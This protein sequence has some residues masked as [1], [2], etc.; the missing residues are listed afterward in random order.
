[1]NTSKK[2]FIATIATLT[3]LALALALGACGGVEDDV[4]FTEETVINTGSG[5][6]NYTCTY[7]PDNTYCSCNG[8]WD[9][10]AMKGK[11][12]SGWGCSGTGSAQTCCCNTNGHPCDSSCG[13][14]SPPEGQT[15]ASKLSTG[16]LLAPQPVYVLSK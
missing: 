9:C 5:T 7:Y 15:C 4:G 13:K 12:T 6:L 11:C 10:A 16:G 1:M 2:T 8:A 3:A 14:H